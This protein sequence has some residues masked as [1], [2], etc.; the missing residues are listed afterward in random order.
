MARYKLEGRERDFFDFESEIF[1]APHTGYLRKIN[2]D[3]F[4]LVFN[5]LIKQNRDAIYY[6]LPP[7]LLE[8]YDPNN[9]VQLTVSEPTYH[10]NGLYK[11]T[12][13]LDTKS[14]FYEVDDID[15]FGLIIRKPHIDKDDLIWFVSSE[16]NNADDD[17]LGVS[18]A[19]Q[20]L[21]A[22][23]IYNNSV[24]GIGSEAYFLR[25]NIGVKTLIDHYKQSIS[26]KIPIEFFRTNS[27]CQYTSVV[28]NKGLMK[29]I[30]KF[31]SKS[32]SELP[33]SILKPVNIYLLYKTN[34]VPTV[35]T[36]I[37]DASPGKRSY[38]FLRDINEYTM[39]AH[40]ITP[41]VDD[42]FISSL[43]KEINSLY[44]S[45]LEEPLFCFEEED[46]KRTSMAVCRLN[47]K[48]KFDT[49]TMM[50]DFNQ[51][52]E[53]TR[54]LEKEIKSEREGYDRYSSDPLLNLPVFIKIVYRRIC[55]IFSTE[56]R[57]T[58]LNELYQLLEDK[59][60]EDKIKK[61]L[62]ILR[63]KGLIYSSSNT[64]WK[65]LYPV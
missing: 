12:T 17:H 13:Y 6:K 15:D 19:L 40:M 57:G 1:S 47:F 37:R 53:L 7:D 51:L 18:I 34:V 24:G 49:K 14:T 33:Y 3:Y 2:G 62:M 38:D 54:D 52:I 60:E 16:W 58:S 63:E 41:T 11:K 27:F 29:L 20:L 23:K 59:L 64:A 36:L 48:T 10:H 9:L 61:A 45:D 31:N 5:P 39:K 8:R 26:S 30:S 28:S 56:D 43:T 42:S 25:K 35:P 21:S 4:Q 44:E 46:I 32:A 22:P 55:G 50:K 65:N